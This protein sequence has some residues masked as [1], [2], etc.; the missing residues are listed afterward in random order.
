MQT[1]TDNVKRWRLILIDW[2]KGLP[3]Y[4]K[5]ITC[6]ASVTGSLIARYLYCKLHRKINNYPPGPTY[7]CIQFDILW[8]TP[9]C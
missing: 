4:Q 8:N 6:V 1:V 9:H 3:T 2:F 7:H 5:I